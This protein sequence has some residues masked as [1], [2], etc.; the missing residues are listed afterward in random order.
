VEPIGH[1]SIVYATAGS[2]KLVAIFEPQQAPRVGETITLTVD[3]TRVHL[4]D[5]ETERS[6]VENDARG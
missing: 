4:F 1:E 2:E 3:P 6:L 5:A